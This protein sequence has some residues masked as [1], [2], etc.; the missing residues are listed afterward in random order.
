M[1]R[2]KTNTMNTTTA[3]KKN[4]RI[5]RRL[6]SRP[7]KRGAREGEGGRQEGWRSS[8]LLAAGLSSR[9]RV[10]WAAGRG[11]ISDTPDRSLCRRGPVSSPSPCSRRSRP[12][13]IST[14]LLPTARSRRHD[15]FVYERGGRGWGGRVDRYTID[16]VSRGRTRSN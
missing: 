8:K 7:E 1:K 9:R 5:D 6:E 16:R 12:G 2:P 15:S 10:S 14:A 13:I 3:R 4:A 11:S